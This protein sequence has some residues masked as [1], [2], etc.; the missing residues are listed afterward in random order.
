MKKFLLSIVVLLS[1]FNTQAEYYWGTKYNNRYYFSDD[2]YQTD[3]IPLR[4]KGDEV[5][6]RTTCPE[7]WIDDYKLFIYDIIKDKNLATKA[8]K[9]NNEYKV[10]KEIEAPD[11]TN[12]MDYFWIYLMYE[13][14]E[15]LDLEDDYPILSKLNKLAPHGFIDDWEFK[16]NT[17][18]CVNPKFVFY[19]TGEKTI[20]YITFYVQYK[21]GAGNLIKDPVSGKSTLTYRGTGPVEYGYSASFDWTDSCPYFIKNYDES[22]ITKVVLEYMD[23]TKYT[24]IK[25]LKFNKNKIEIWE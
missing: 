20:K 3:I 23:G 12:I 2:I 9:F 25:E 19:N 24:L 18:G 21:D 17:L 1:F 5:L 10:A 6:V 15:L 16:I 4:V 7:Y 11:Y 14:Q 22:K 13:S 8:I